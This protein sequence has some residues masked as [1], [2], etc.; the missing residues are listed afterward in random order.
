MKRRKL[1]ESADNEIK[2]VGSE[3][4]MYDDDDEFGHT[5]SQTR[6]VVTED[7]IVIE[8]KSKSPGTVKKLQE[9]AS[10]KMLVDQN[11]AH[12]HQL[13]QQHLQTTDQLLHHSPVGNSLQLS[14]GHQAGFSFDQ[15]T[16]HGLAPQLGL[17][18]LGLPQLGLPQLGLP[19]QFRLVPELGLAPQLDLG[20]QMG[21]GHQLSPGHHLGIVQ[22][23]GLGQHLGIGQYLGLGQPVPAFGQNQQVKAPQQQ[24]GHQHQAQY[25]LNK[26]QLELELEYQKEL[27]KKNHSLKMRE[28][29]STGN[30]ETKQKHSDGVGRKESD[31]IEGWET[32]L[33]RSIPFI[34]AVDKSDPP[35]DPEPQVAGEAGQEQNKMI[36]EETKRLN[37]ELRKAKV[38]VRDPE[39]LK[40]PKQKH[41]RETKESDE[42]ELEHTK[43]GI[44]ETPSD[45]VCFITASRVCANIKCLVRHTAADPLQQ[46]S[47]CSKIAYCGEKCQKKGW[48]AHRV[49]CNKMKGASWEERVKQVT[50]MLRLGKDKSWTKAE[51]KSKSSEKMRRNKGSVANFAA[52]IVA[53]ELVVSAKPTPAS[54]CTAELVVR[55]PECEDQV[56]LRL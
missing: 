3:F 54:H 56:K 12:N 19:P 48:V 51:E 7:T 26:Y 25:L 8:K 42:E 37:K 18:Q 39:E 29:G 13:L 21:L 10:K 40:R 27:L 53:E 46:C 35:V 36:G 16:R 28:L 2:E 43:I 22:Q 5:I 30:S 1:E 23:L 38:K 9:E 32:E 34:N 31:E 44:D 55:V 33:P 17:A 15:L 11:V 52:E 50:V 6:R 24:H 47:G 4:F 14:L 45:L 20:Q 41:T 49:V